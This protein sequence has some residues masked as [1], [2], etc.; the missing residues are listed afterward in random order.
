MRKIIA[1]ILIV[2]LIASLY[3]YYSSATKKLNLEAQQSKIKIS[4]A[5]IL[6]KI[7]E[8]RDEILNDLRVL[9]QNPDQLAEFNCLLTKVLYSGTIT[10]EDI[11][12]LLNFQREYYTKQTIEKNPEQANYER[13]QTEINE[14]RNAK[15][16]IIGY[17]IVGPQYVDVAKDE[18][19]LIIFNAIY[20]LNITSDQGDV[21]K[22]Y[23]F[24]QNKDKLWELKGFGTIEDFAVVH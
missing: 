17:K 13:L 21:F 24:E 22:G 6:P 14:Y 5:T 16:S 15:V 18:K 1:A 19:E 20:Y 4:E 2:G 7:K 3:F 23:V 9:Q 10:D 8:N 11:K 12:L